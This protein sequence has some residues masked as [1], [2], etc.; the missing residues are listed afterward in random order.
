MIKRIP[1]PIRD[2]KVR[3]PPTRA[4]D[5]GFVGMFLVNFIFGY[6]P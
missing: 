6:P 5:I 1:Y 3:V 4:M 2:R